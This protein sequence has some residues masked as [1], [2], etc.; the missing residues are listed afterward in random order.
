[1]TREIGLLQ[2]FVLSLDVGL[3][4]GNKRKIELAESLALGVVTVSSKAAMHLRLLEMLMFQDVP[5]SKSHASIKLYNS[6]TSRI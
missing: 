4:S 3:W 2:A 6:E 1:V 5:A